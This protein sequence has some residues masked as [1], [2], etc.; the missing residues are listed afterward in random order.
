M[1]Y[2]L[3]GAELVYYWLTYG[4]MTGVMVVVAVYLLISKRSAFTDT[5]VRPAQKIRRLAGC[6]LA[7]MA[8]EYLAMLLYIPCYA[9]FLDG[10]PPSYSPQAASIVG[11]LYILLFQTILCWFVFSLFQGYFSMKK[12]YLLISVLPPVVLLVLTVIWEYGL[13]GKPLLGS[14]SVLWAAQLFWLVYV[15]LG[16][17]VFLFY[18]RRYRKALLDNYSDLGRKEVRWIY[19]LA[20]ITILYMGIYFVVYSRGEYTYWGSIIDQVC[21]VL[22]AI[23]IVYQVDVMEYIDWTAVVPVSD[24]SLAP[25]DV[26]ESVEPVPAG[27]A[28]DEV[29]VRLEKMLQKHCVDAQLYLNQDLTR[30]DLVRALGTNRTYLARYFSL[31]GM[32]FN[33]YINTLRIEYACSLI[34][35]KDPQRSLKDIAL[36]SGFRSQEVFSRRFKMQKGCTPGEFERANF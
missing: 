32:T 20:L 22:L 12:R 24:S 16:C 15:I 10:M 17:T 3:E 28:W 2:Y 26:A 11:Q 21:A 19:R 13:G 4:I 23:Y 9:D 34:K 8:L 1:F 30:E 5:V 18:M 27:E 29:A 25:A 7:V 35:E 6:A 14:F 33:S 31:K 36:L